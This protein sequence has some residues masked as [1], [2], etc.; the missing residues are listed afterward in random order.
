MPLYEY[1]CCGATFEKILPIEKRET[2][3]PECG[4]K[5]YPKIAAN[6]RHWWVGQPEW[7]NAWN[8][9]ERMSTL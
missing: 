1:D 4:K 3:C 8:H 2:E 9:G 7:A 5:I 6:V